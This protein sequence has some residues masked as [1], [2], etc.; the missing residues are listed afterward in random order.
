MKNKP[1]P[2]ISIDNFLSKKNYNY[3]KDSF[4]SPN[5][6]IWKKP[7]NRNTQGKSVTVQGRHNLKELQYD[8]KARSVFFELNSGL[9]IR[10][11]EKVTGI[12]GLIPDPF[13][14]ESGF[15]QM[16]K[17]GFLNVHSDFSHHD[18]LGL[19]RRVNLLFYLN[20]DWKKEYN[21]YLS[22]Y[23]KKIN[24]I[25]S[26][27]PKAN[28]CII[29]TTSN[30]S[31]HGHPEPLMSPKGIFRKSIAMYY[32]TLPTKKRLKKR[33]VFPTDRNFSFKV[34]KN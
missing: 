25:S 19:E 34:S 33:I 7:N 26:Y 27:A 22:L 1:F 28:R 20:E 21:G 31:Y 4:P 15:H 2:H 6:K 14:A 23:D 13:F 17:D 9:F 30:I 10:F 12:N 8:Q 16:E 5:N 24:K 18:S 11:L 3:I 32:Y 29:F